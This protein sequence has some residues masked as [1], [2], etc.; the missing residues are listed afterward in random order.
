[1]ILMMI[2]AGGRK[3]VEVAGVAPPD[4]RKFEEDRKAIVERI[5]GLED[6]IVSCRY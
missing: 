5:I 1:M 3:M 6:K 4:L 2:S